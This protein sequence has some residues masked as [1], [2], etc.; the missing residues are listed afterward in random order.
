MDFT[1]EFEGD[2]ITMLAYAQLPGTDKKFEGM[3][4]NACRWMQC[5]VVKS[6]KQT[7]AYSLSMNKN[8][9][10]GLFNVRWSMKQGDENKCCFIVKFKIE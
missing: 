1:P 2:D 4:A 7:Y 8:Y 6:T 5:P 10:K 3:D 9:P